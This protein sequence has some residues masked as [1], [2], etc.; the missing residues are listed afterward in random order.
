[1]MHTIFPDFSSNLVL[2]VRTSPI[3]FDTCF[4]VLKYY[5]TSDSFFLLL[6]V[7]CNDDI[8]SRI[9]A[10]SMTNPRIVK[11]CWRVSASNQPA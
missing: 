4:K 3:S 7:F 9:G 1:M 10:G 6:A 11:K 8:T 5:T 2:Q